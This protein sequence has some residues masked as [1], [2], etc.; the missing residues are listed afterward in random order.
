MWIPRPWTNVYGLS[1]TLL[2]LG[3]LSV[4]LFATT[5][6]LFSFRGDSGL[7]PTC[8]GLESAIVFCVLP[9]DQLWITHLAAILILAIAASGWRPRITCIPQWYIHASIFLGLSSPDGGEQVAAVLSLLIVPIALLDGRTWHWQREES[10]TR[11]RSS[12]SQQWAVAIAVALVVCI[13]LQAFI[14][15]IQASFAKLPHDD[16]ANGTGFYYWASDPIFGVADW[17]VP[18][19]D[20]LVDTP[21]FLVALTWGPI[22]LEVAIALGLLMPSKVRKWILPAGLAFHLAIGILIGL[23]SFA[24]SMWAL[25]LIA[26]YPVGWTLRDMWLFASER[27]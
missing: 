13:K 20:F 10:P 4:L 19:I 3:A 23:W 18:V 6:D 27:G 14:I 9:R 11:E 5:D 12:F 22:L 17:L 2:A 25:L 15:Y 1:R 26:F 16:W 8:H 7:K 24:F 21:V